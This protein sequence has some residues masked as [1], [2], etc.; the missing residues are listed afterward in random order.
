METQDEVFPVAATHEQIKQWREDVLP[1]LERILEKHLPV[2]ES[3]SIDLLG[4]GTC[5]KKCRPTI[6]V[7][8][9]SRRFVKDILKK[10]A[11]DRTAFSLKVRKGSVQRSS[12]RG[13]GDRDSKHQE[14]PLPGAS[15]GACRDGVPLPAATYGGLVLVDE[16]P[17]GLTVHH[18]VDTEEEQNTWGVG[19]LVET[20]AGCHSAVDVDVSKIHVR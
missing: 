2:E 11:Y 8:C 18:L 5:Q 16:R 17:Y 13:G 4:I 1:R 3:V 15:I 14:R 7:T 19:E 10:F 20:Y 6:V 12:C 9:K